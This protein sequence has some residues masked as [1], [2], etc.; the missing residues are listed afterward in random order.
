MNLL[1]NKAKLLIHEKANFFK[2]IETL[3]IELKKL[4]KIVSVLKY[5]HNTFDWTLIE[6]DGE[7]R[8][9]SKKWLNELWE[10]GT[11]I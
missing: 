3:C 10:N 6:V 9:I 11:R 8:K 5:S 7:E 1:F 2:L 4:L